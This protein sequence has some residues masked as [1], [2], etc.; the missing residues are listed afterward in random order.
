MESLRT[1]VLAI[2][3]GLTEFLPISSS[4]H[5]ILVPQLLGWPDQGLAFD[6]AVHVGTL[7]AVLAYF[8]D[9]LTEVARA[10]FASF[11]GEMTGDARLGWAVLLGTVPVGVAGLVFGDFIETHLRSPMVIAATTIGFGALL[12]FADLRGARNHDE[13]S[14]SWR[15]IIVI[16]CAQAL[17]LV[18]GTSRSGITMTAGLLIGLDRAG[19]ARFS[20]L[21]S[22]PVI[23]LAGGFET[24]KLVRSPEPVDLLALSLGAIVSAVSAYLCIRLFLKFL[25]RTGMAPFAIYRF[26]LGA[27]I[28][29]VY[30]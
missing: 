11:G 8:R 20:F 15:E 17:A 22:I 18:P 6:V 9:E 16:G 25:E 27:L 10:W 21:L 23:V 28:L 24:M 4:G 7:I 2:V 3:Q 14:M 5:L 29:A 12:W 30:W 19:A 13:H 1:T 26:V